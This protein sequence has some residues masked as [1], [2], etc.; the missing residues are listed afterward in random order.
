ML[1]VNFA[2]QNCWWKLLPSTFLEQEMHIRFFMGSLALSFSSQRVQLRVWRG[3][4]E[5]YFSLD[6]KGEFGFGVGSGGVMA[7]DDAEGLR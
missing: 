1:V 6:E 4:I 5:L 2:T 7:G 3:E